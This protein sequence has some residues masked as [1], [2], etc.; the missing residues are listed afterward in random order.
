[1]MR[2]LVQ[3]LN[4]SLHQVGVAPIRFFVITNSQHEWTDS[5]RTTERNGREARVEFREGL[6]LRIQEMAFA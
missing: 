5:L 4:Q 3:Q 1:M 2:A 6:K